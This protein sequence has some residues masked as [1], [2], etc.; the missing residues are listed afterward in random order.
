MLSSECLYRAL[1]LGGNVWK[2]WSHCFL[3][4]HP[5]SLWYSFPS[6]YPQGPGEA[7]EQGIALAPPFLST[8]AASAFSPSIR[9]QEPS[10]GSHGGL[11]FNF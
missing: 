4:P 10:G 1:L 2:T 9:N 3:P 7:L 6:P 8:D 11:I 5:L